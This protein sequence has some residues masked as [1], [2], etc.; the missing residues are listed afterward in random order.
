MRKALKKL[1]KSSVRR[2]L[3]SLKSTTPTMNSGQT[4]WADLPPVEIPDE[5]SGY[6]SNNWTAWDENTNSQHA[7]NEFGNGPSFEQTMVPNA[8]NQ[9]ASSHDSW[10]RTVDSAIHSV[11]QVRIIAN[12]DDAAVEVDFL[13]PVIGRRIMRGTYLLS[14]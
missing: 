4:P 3:V 12:T 14:S 13:N 10:P 7:L 5:R 9:C 8:M 11:D 6:V 1:L 2:L